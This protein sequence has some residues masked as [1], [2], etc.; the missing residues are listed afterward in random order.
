[1]LAVAFSSATAAILSNSKKL[2]N[3]GNN[4]EQTS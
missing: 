2:Q 4:Y 3:Y 1:M